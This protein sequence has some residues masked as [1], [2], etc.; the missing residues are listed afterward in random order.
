MK[1]LKTNP[2]ES[3]WFYPVRGELF[4]TIKIAIPPYRHILEKHHK[5]NLQIRS[6]LKTDK[7]GV[8]IFETDI[9]KYEARGEVIEFLVCY[10]FDTASFFLQTPSMR[11]NASLIK[12]CEKIGNYYQ[13]YNLRLLWDAKNPKLNK[14]TRQWI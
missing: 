5:L 3:K 9:V 8:E 11:I 2:R 4:K 12:K 10:C 7:N 13:D 1:A 6:L 14:N